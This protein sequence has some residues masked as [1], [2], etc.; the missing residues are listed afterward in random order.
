MY[1]EETLNKWNMTA[2]E[3][4][5]AVRKITVKGYRLTYDEK[6]ELLFF[7][8]E[9]IIARDDD[10]A[11][12][13]HIE[14]SRKLAQE[15][16]NDKKLVREFVKEW[17]RLERKYDGLDADIEA[18]TL[19]ELVEMWLDDY[20]ELYFMEKIDLIKYYGAKEYAQVYCYNVG[21][22]PASEVSMWA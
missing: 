2:D 13:K 22:C 12:V 4:D 6:E 11:I 3:C 18:K 16:E 21:V 15:W 8:E 19:D 17:R 20:F 14:F 9:G 1:N 5:K 10:D 7:F